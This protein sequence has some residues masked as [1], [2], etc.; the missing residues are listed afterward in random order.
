MD[1]FERIRLEKE[2][3]TKPNK[4]KREIYLIKDV[5]RGLVK[6]G[7]AKN[8]RIRFSQL[9]TANA[10]IELIKFYHGISIDERLLHKHFK[11]IGKRV[12]GEWFS[13]SCED[14]DFIDSYFSIR[15]YDKH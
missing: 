2:A 11:T 5:G 8:T 6:I 4:E 9:K 14:L 3:T 10:G 7:V 1:E 13:L 15:Y 12:D